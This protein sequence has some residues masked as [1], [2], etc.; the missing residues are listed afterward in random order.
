MVLLSKLCRILQNCFLAGLLS[1]IVLNIGR[2]TTDNRNL[3]VSWSLL[4]LKGM[5][6][7]STRVLKGLVGKAAVA[8]QIIAECIGR[9]IFNRDLF[10]VP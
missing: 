3:A 7:A 2:V 4:N 10:V 5:T 9:N 6:P 1:Q 8:I